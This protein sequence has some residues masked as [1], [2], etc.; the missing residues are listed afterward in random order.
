MNVTERIEQL[1]RQRNWTMYRLGK[2]AKLPQSTL[3]HVFRRDSEPTISTLEAICE[4]FGIT[5]GE[6]FSDGEFVPLTAEQRSL[7][8]KWA[9][10]SKEQKQLI[11]SVIDHMK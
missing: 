3:T 11:F 1:M 10:L 6:F 9:V 5:L 8:D 4:A 2:E 7:L